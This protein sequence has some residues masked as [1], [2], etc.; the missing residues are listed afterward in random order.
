MLSPD[1]GFPLGQ[2]TRVTQGWTRLTRFQSRKASLS[3]EGHVFLNKNA[4]RSDK[5]LSIQDVIYK[6]SHEQKSLSITSKD[7]RIHSAEFLYRDGSWW[8][9]TIDSENDE[10]AFTLDLMNLLGCRIDW[11]RTCVDSVQTTVDGITTSTPF[12]DFGPVRFAR[13]GTVIIGGLHAYQ[14]RQVIPDVAFENFVIRRRPRSIWC[15]LTCQ[16]KPVQC[17]DIVSG[18]NYFFVYERDGLW[19]QLVVSGFLSPFRHWYRNAVLAS[20]LLMKILA[21]AFLV[22]FLIAGAIMEA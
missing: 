21:V 9:K 19:Y 13:N 10:V 16:R 1:N 3:P 8:A 18:H 12:Y 6:Y 11:S 15:R 4:L 2:H 22:C 5:V 20:P 14:D 7:S 17:C